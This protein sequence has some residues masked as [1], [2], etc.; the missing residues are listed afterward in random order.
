L[1]FDLT[2]EELRIPAF[3]YRLLNQAG[4]VQS[5]ETLPAPE[6][7]QFQLC[8]ALPVADLKPG[9]YHFILSGV[10]DGARNEIRRLQL[11]VPK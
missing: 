2:E 3:S 11:E 9:S 4:A 7:R 10:R 5:S 6:V 8:L 1:F